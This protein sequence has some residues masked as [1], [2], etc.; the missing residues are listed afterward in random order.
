MS[1]QHRERVLSYVILTVLIVAGGAFAGYQMLVKPLGEKARRLTDLENEKDDKELRLTRIREEQ[2]KVKKLLPLSLPA[3]VGAARRDYADELAKIAREA[4]FESGAFPITPKE[5]DTKSSPQLPNKKPAYTRLDYVIPGARG[6]LATLVDF[7]ER[8]YKLPLLHQIKTLTV[9]KPLTTTRAGSNDLDITMTIEAL[10]LD[11]APK[12][13]TLLPPSTVKAP[14]VLAVPERKY[15][16]IAGKNIFFGPPMREVVK[17]EI[18]FAEFV[19]CDSITLNE[20]GPVV[21]LFD[22]YNNQNYQV[23]PVNGRFKVEVSYYLAG[24]RKTLR[25][26]PD[27]VIENERGDPQYRWAVVRID[28]RELILRDEDG[29][30]CV[31]HV[32]QTLAECTR[33]SSSQ[34]KE[35]GLEETK[36]EGKKEDGKAAAKKAP[37]GK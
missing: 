20:A 30:L 1:M 17:Q 33:L 4:G 25:T 35:L 11:Q 15:A 9:Q 36:D 26:N 10:V 16:S 12:R 37:G 2:E 5:P 32:G 22:S 19:K 6:D 3:D 18:D 27:L 7:M 21:T 23:S 34:L 8:F 29:K 31:V 24:K 14:P 13:E 28:P